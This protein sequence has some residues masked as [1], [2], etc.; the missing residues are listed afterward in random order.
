MPGCARRAPGDIAVPGEHQP[1]PSGVR[2]GSLGGRQ[3]PPG[4]RQSCRDAVTAAGWFIPHGSEVV[5]EAVAVMPARPCPG[6]A[7]RLGSPEPENADGD[8]AGREVPAALPGG[9][10]GDLSS[11]HPGDSAAQML[12]I[13]SAR[14]SAQ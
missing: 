3:L 13:S 11:C 9:G 7:A 14:L 10:D 6:T 2:G 8:A 12:N 4:T 5:S 1:L